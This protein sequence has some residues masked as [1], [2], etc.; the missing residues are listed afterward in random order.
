LTGGLS[1][2]VAIGVALGVAAFIALLRNS[3]HLEGI[4]AQLVAI[5]SE[6]RS[7]G[8]RIDSL[9]LEIRPI[10]EGVEQIRISVESLEGSTIYQ[11]DDRSE[12]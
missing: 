8:E 1:W 9:E 7:L 5:R 4:L 3:D 11:Q 6:I 10:V 12:Y 2:P